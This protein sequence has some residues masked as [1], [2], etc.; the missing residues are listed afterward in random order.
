MN[1]THNRNTIWGA[2]LAVIALGI[3]ASAGP[4]AAQP[5]LL[6]H[7]A[8]VR[9]TFGDWGHDNGWN[10]DGDQG[11]DRGRDRER[12]IEQERLRVER[13]RR[14]AERARHEA[15]VRHAAEVRHEQW[16]REHRRDG[17]RDRHDAYGDWRND[18]RR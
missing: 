10:H 3:A 4:A 1:N 13:E 14:E 9:Q 6:S 12:H 15:E 17:D 18:D 8:Q 11:R 7:P 5:M 16:L 2:G